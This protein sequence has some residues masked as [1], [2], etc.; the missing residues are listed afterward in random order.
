MEDKEIFGEFEIIQDEELAEV[1]AELLEK[2]VAVATVEKITRQ[3]MGKTAGVA[4]EWAVEVPE[5]PVVEVAP[6]AA[7]KVEA[8]EKTVDKTHQYSAVSHD[9]YN[10]KYYVTLPN[11]ISKG[12]QNA[13]TKTE[14]RLKLKV[15]LG[16]E[17]IVNEDWYGC[18]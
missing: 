6:V 3:I 17:W 12:I 4:V 10:G 13:I 9:K 16:Y 7:K 1:P 5:I 11:V 15:N 2:M 18:H 8:K 14:E